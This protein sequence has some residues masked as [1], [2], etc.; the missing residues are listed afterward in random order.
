M[1]CLLRPRAFTWFL[2]KLGARLHEPGLVQLQAFDWKRVDPGWR[3]VNGPPNLA[4][5]LAND[6]KL[7]V[8]IEN[9]I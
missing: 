4:N 5:Y 9:W 7:C 1:F 3:P 2:A 6:L 8:H